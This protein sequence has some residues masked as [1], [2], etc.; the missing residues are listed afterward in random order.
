M[1]GFILLASMLDDSEVDIFLE[2]INCVAFNL[3]LYFYG[4]N[5]EGK[6][7]W[8]NTRRRCKEINGIN[9]NLKKTD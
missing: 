4:S 3:K 2:Y 5:S 6:I 7:S 8:L 9:K 1:S